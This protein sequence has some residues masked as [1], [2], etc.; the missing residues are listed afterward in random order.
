MTDEIIEMV[1]RAEETGEPI[2]RCLEYNY[3]NCGYAHIK[4]EYMLEDRY[5][6]APVTEKGALE[7]RVVIPKGEWLSDDGKVYTEG[8]YTISAPIDRLIYFKNCNFYK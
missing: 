1:T 5:L 3:P 8:E 2:L 7:R 4:D 6:I